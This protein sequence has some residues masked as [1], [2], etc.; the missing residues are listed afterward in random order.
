MDSLVT[1][2]TA[3][4][5][6][7]RRVGFVRSEGR[8]ADNL[9]RRMRE[10]ILR[11]LN[12]KK[13]PF[14]TDVS[15]RPIRLDGISRRDGVFLE[16]LRTSA[17]VDLLQLILGPN[18]ALLRNRHNHA[19]LNRS[20]DIPFRL[21]RDVLQWSRAIITVIVYLEDANVDNG[22]TYVVPGSQFERFAGMPPDGGG[23]NWAEDHSEYAHLMNQAVPVPMKS[24]TVL[25]IDSL[26]FHSVGINHTDSS[27]M[28]ITFAIRSVD[29]LERE[30]ENYDL[31][32]GQWV[33]KGND[34]DYNTVI[35]AHNVKQ[36]ES[37]EASRLISDG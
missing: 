21:H 5:N 7:F 3:L 37:A 22:C 18:V 32:C 35:P 28:S 36:A 2:D 10:V 14:R 31:L 4:Y 20:G 9:I 19:T 1:K 12:E 16:A 26:V 17:V 30:T 23:G 24:G 13:R 6:H 33:Y 29:E 11:D 27:R 34:L 8:I 25:A 15:G